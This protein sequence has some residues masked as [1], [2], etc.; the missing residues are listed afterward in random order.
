MSA[1]ERAL[2][3]AFTPLLDRAKRRVERIKQLQARPPTPERDGS[4]AAEKREIELVKKTA[5]AAGQV[6]STLQ[7]AANHKVAQAE[8]AL[9]R[10]RDTVDEATHYETLFHRTVMF[11]PDLPDEAVP[12]LVLRGYA[13]LIRMHH[14][15]TSPETYAATFPAPFANPTHL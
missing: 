5:E 8:A 11:A 13:A 4:I 9:Q 15:C 6:L 1:A 12:P 2:Q 14:I 3:K 10:V 7:Y